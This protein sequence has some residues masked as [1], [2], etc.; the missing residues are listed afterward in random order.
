MFFFEKKKNEILCKYEIFFLPL[1][2]NYFRTKQ[3][4]GVMQYII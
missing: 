4:S 1:V 2:A 3:K